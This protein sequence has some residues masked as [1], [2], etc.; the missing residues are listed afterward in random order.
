MWQVSENFAILLKNVTSVGNLGNLPPSSSCLSLADWLASGPRQRG[1]QRTGGYW[2][3]TELL[4]GLV[5]SHQ[6]ITSTFK[7]LLVWQRTIG[8]KYFHHG[9]CSL[10]LGWEQGGRRWTSPCSCRWTPWCRRTPPRQ[11]GGSQSS[12]CG[13]TWWWQ[14]YRFCIQSLST[15]CATIMKLWHWQSRFTWVV[16]AILCFLREKMLGTF[17]TFLHWHPIVSHFPKKWVVGW[18]LNSW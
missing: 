2:Q 3:N 5:L 14:F 6:T 9:P 12:C 11:S 1:R 17:Y 4:S 10:K 8:S 15:I 13:P 16:T 18:I 7:L